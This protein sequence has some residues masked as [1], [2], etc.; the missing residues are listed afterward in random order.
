MLKA[1]KTVND[2]FY[3]ALE[4]GKTYEEIEKVEGFD[5]FMRSKL[6]RD[7]KTAMSRALEKMKKSLGV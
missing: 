6:E 5:E 1:I 3:K 4:A 2:W 7:Y